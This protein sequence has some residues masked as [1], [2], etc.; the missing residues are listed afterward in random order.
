[1]DIFDVLSMLGG[2][3]LLLYGMEVMGK[4]LEKLSGGR[5]ESLLEKMTSNRF[6]AVLLGAAVTAAIQSSSATTVMVVGFVNSGIMKLGQAV[7]IIMGANIGTTITS[8]ILSLAGLDG[9]NIFIKL[10][11]PTSFAPVMA[12]IGII[13]VMFSKKEKKKDIGSILLG[14]AI[15]MTGMDIM[16]DAVSGLTEIPGFKNIMLMFSNPILGMLAGAV[17][18]GIIQSSAASIGI[19]QAFCLS[20]SITYGTAIPIIMGQNIGTC[21]TAVLS[22]L[23]A[24]KN[25]KRTAAVHLYFN[26]IGTLVFMAVFYGINAVVD[27]AFLADAIPSAHIALIH[28][29]FNI[30]ATVLLF[31][32]AGVLEKL[33]VW[34]IK[35]KEGEAVVDTEFQVLDE[36][37]LDTPAY[38]LE[39]CKNLTD[40]MAC[41]TRDSLF[42]G[43][44]LLSD[45]SESRAEELMQVESLV[46]R[47]EDELGS[48]LV[49]LSSRDL[50]EKDSKMV[51]TLLHSIGNWERIS[52]HAVNLCDAAKEIYEKKLS[53]SPQATEELAVFSRAIRDIMGMTVE[54]FETEDIVLAKKVEPLEEVIDTLNRKIRDR[55]IK[56]LRSGECTIELGFV[57]T[58][59][60]GNFERV[61]DHCSNLAVDVI[62]TGDSAVEAHEYLDALKSADNEQFRHDYQEV[63]KN[64]LLPTVESAK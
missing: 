10:L 2:L 30:G 16:G 8:W 54:A 59:I 21:V 39:Q 60:L 33:A 13:F 26:L 28:S 49:K 5:L 23:G 44:E 19:L 61:S 34:T 48:Y 7:G 36:R 9:S 45:Y 47:Y 32:F 24:S 43:I 1:M 52:D 11:K 29:A 18:T 46:D 64:Y 56:R 12:L 6:K 58:D 37:F 40:K 25:A 3:A 38:A 62:Q 27:F 31:P 50:S 63:K 4:S 20:G 53:F 15:L 57:L 42:E 14:F 17:L 22:S 51:S 35:D 41:I 55:H